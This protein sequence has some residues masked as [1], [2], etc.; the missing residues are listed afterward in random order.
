VQR[1]IAPVGSGRGVGRVATGLLVVAT[2][3]FGVARIF[4]SGRPV[5]G[6]VR[7]AAEAGMVGGL[8]DWFAVT[9]L[10]RHPLGI[11]IPHTA[12]IPERKAALGV[13]LGSFVQEN[14]LSPE[15]VV[16]KVR[17]ARVSQRVTQWLS[18]SD[19]REVVTNRVVS[20]I[21]AAA[22]RMQNDETSSAVASFVERRL[23]AVPAAPVLA[24]V[25][26]GA[27][28]DGRHHALLD[29]LLDHLRTYLLANTDVLRARVSRSSP[30]WVPGSVDERMFQRMIDGA[31]QLIDDVRADHRHVLRRPA[32]RFGRRTANRS[33]NDRKGGGLETSGARPS[34]GPGMDRVP[35]VTGARGARR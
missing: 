6:F 32:P 24:A 25:L 5:V 22:Q 4:E 31:T 34:R 8:A 30:W 29:S 3:V 19:N 33:G 2:V 23:A 13:G 12:L 11:P 16:G 9:A 27:S 10:F 17:D 14:F 1:A 21:Q 28:S 26:E 7:A 35:V 15:L 18:T 20:L